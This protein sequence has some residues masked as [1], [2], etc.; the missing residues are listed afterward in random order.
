MIDTWELKLTLVRDNSRIEWIHAGIRGKCSW[1][2]RAGKLRGNLSHREAFTR[3]A[4]KQR[5]ERWLLQ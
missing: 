1:C 4:A 2:E 5:E 3:P